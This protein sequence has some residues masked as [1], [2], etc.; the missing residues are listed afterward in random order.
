[1]QLPS[2][3]VGLAAVE[4]EEMATL[5][6][7]FGRG[8]RPGPH[9]GTTRGDPRATAPTRRRGGWW[10]R[11]AAVTV[12]GEAACRARPDGA[13]PPGGGRRAPR[14][15]GSGNASIAWCIRGPT[16]SRG[17]R[18]AGHPSRRAGAV[19][20]VR[21]GE[22]L[23]DRVVAVELALIS[24]TAS[25]T[26]S[27]PSCPRSAAAPAGASRSAV[28]SGSM[29]ASP[30]FAC[31]RPAMIFRRVD[32]PVVAA[33]SSDLGAVQEGQGDVVEDDL[34]AV[35]LANVLRSVKTYSAMI[36]K[37]KGETRPYAI[38]VRRPG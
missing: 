18:S 15:A 1:M 12:A 16:R 37:P 26:F 13:R 6:R 8:S 11:R 35:G 14:E 17:R 21:V 34:V 19:V 25:S 20:G 32:L 4:L 24:P 7:R 31:S 36:R 5:S 10:A 2:V 29:S 28:A 23:G 38:R 30:L 33:A 9:G 27:K 3:R 22:L